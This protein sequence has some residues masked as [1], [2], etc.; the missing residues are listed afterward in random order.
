[1]YNATEF[2]FQINAVLF[3]F[4]YLIENSLKKLNASVYKDMKMMQL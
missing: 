4:V 3:I 1:M 2:L